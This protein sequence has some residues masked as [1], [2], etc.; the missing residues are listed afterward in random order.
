MS[1]APYWG[2]GQTRACRKYIQTANLSGINV[3]HTIAL[4]YKLIIDSPGCVDHWIAN[5][6]WPS[7]GGS[8]LEVLSHAAVRQA[9]AVKLMFSSLQD[10]LR[11]REESP[12]T[13][14]LA[15]D[16]VRRRRR[17]APPE[18]SHNNNSRHLQAEYYTVP[19]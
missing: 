1:I 5:H 9:M 8:G 18:A 11:C 16:G 6:L 3:P 2:L 12:Q 4:Q 14:W 13:C 19:Q 17:Q 10:L 15:A 7:L